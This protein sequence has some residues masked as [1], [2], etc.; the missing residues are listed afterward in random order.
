MQP[1]SACALAYVGYSGS[2]RGRLIGSVLPCA[3]AP[4]AV[5]KV[6]TWRQEGPD[7][8]RQ[9]PPRRGGDLRQRAGAARPRALSRW[10]R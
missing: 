1:S 7:G 4:P 2:A 6:E 3:W 10:A 8:F 9:V 5:A